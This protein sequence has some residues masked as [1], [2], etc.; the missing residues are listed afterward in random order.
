M[1]G[2]TR[3]LKSIIAAAEAYDGQLPWTRGTARAAAI[4]RRRNAA[5]AKRSA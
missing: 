1:K 2:K 5:L 4:A 3:F